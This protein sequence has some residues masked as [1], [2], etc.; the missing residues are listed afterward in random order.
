MCQTESSHVWQKHF[1]SSRS[2]HDAGL[3]FCKVTTNT[4]SKSANIVCEEEEGLLIHLIRRR[5]LPS[6]QTPE[7]VYLFCWMCLFAPFH[8]CP[9]PLFS[10]GRTYVTLVVPFCPFTVPSL[11]LVEKKRK[12]EKEKKIQK[13]KK[14]KQKK[15]EK[16]KEK[17]RSEKLFLRGNWGRKAKMMSK[18]PKVPPHYLFLFF[19][20][21]FPFSEAI[22]IWIEFVS[23]LGII[24]IDWSTITQD[25]GE[26]F[27]GG[28]WMDQRAPTQP[29]TL[30]P[31]A[32]PTN[33]GP[34]HPPL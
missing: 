16:W 13:E 25:S 7:Q 26:N 2:R 4:M 19:L 11:V 20:S 17:K 3:S 15:R 6:D 14:K 9:D 31:Q 21:F 10:V 8:V 18:K 23:F 33:H 1:W 30:A 34:A 22:T 28:W 27:L 12:R 29:L 24:I 32:P 5:G